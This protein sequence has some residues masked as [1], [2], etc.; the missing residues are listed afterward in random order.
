MKCISGVMH[1]CMA[2]S[3]S[4]PIVVHILASIVTHANSMSELTNLSMQSLFM[5]GTSAAISNVLQSLLSVFSNTAS[6]TLCWS[7]FVVSRVRSQSSRGEVKACPHWSA[8]FASICVVEF[9]SAPLNTFCNFSAISLQSVNEFDLVT[10][11]VSFMAFLCCAQ[12]CDATTTC[13][14]RRRQK[15]CQIHGVLQG[16]FFCT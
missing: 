2:V 14:E 9:C 3:S 1:G 15:C 8:A 13:T 12:K 11:S 5:L 6:P 4:C 16:G 10:P 7:L